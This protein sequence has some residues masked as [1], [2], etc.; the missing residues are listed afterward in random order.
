MEEATKTAQELVK[1]LE[2]RKLR[3]H[4]VAGDFKVINDD[5]ILWDA[6]GCGYD[7][8]DFP[9]MFNTLCRLLP[10]GWRIYL[11]AG[12]EKGGRRFELIRD[13]DSPK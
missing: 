10:K 11:A 3:K 4:Q 2:R 13:K 1:F 9:E 6:W 12:E 8:Q 5:E 7:D